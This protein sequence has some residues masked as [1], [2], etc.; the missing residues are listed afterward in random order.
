MLAVVEQL[1]DLGANGEAHRSRISRLDL[2]HH[3]RHC[4]N[5]KP[6]V[7]AKTSGKINPRISLAEKHE[8]FVQIVMLRMDIDLV[9]PHIPF[10]DVGRC[11]SSR[12]ATTSIMIG[13]CPDG[14]DW[15]AF[16]KCLYSLDECSGGFDLS[17]RSHTTSL[18][19][20]S[21]PFATPQS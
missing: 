17:Y 6:K 21:T 3:L 2:D 1:A 20:H 14:S 7:V 15:L 8:L 16:D 18:P 11:R 4:V 9:L 13:R 12:S 19:G 10:V 5:R